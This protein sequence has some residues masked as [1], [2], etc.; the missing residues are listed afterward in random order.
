MIASVA[1]LAAGS[2]VAA[3]STSLPMLVV[4]RLVGGLGAGGG[5]VVSY[6]TVEERLDGSE[7]LRAL[8]IIAAFGGTASG[9]GTLVGGTLAEWVGWRWVV[10]VPAVGLLALVPAARLAPTT[11]DPRQRIDLTGAASLA[12]V[13]GAVITLLQARATGLGMPVLLAVAAV[14]VL[15]S[16]VLVVRVRRRPDGFVPREVVSAPG[17]LPAGFIGL[18]IVAGYYGLLYAAPA[19]LERTFGWS[20]LAVGLALL[21]A[22]LCSLIA[23]RVVGGLAPRAA[24]WRITAGLGALTAGGLVLAA[25]LAHS[26]ALIGAVALVTAGFAGAQAV[27]V[28]LA[29]SLVLA[30]DR[31]VALGLFNV[32]FYGGGAVGPAIVGGLSVASV[33]LAL[34]VVAALP[35]LGTALS[36]LARPGSGDGTDRSGCEVPRPCLEQTG[37][38]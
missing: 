29:P 11:H 14:A 19:L 18:S 6:A 25:A 9:T 7:R 2:S 17:F 1:L 34:A 32:L 24:P 8:A 31:K 3:V 26:V 30:R 5:V 15:S 21:P 23:A 20:S 35:V 10:A 12:A 13:G 16:S 28:G 33:P 36:L 4:G 22:A 38:D 37:A 27:L